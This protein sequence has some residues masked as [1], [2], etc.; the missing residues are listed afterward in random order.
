MVQGFFGSLFAFA[1]VGG[2]LIGGVLVDKAS[3][4]WCFY[5]NLPIGAV[6]AVVL[7]L[8]LKLP[9]P[10]NTGVT[11][12]QK[13][14]KLDPPG[15]LCLIPGVVCLLLA[16]QWGGSVYAWNN[17]RIIALLLL[18][19]VLL[20][21]FVCVQ[22]WR[23]ESG[24]VPPRI[25]KQ[26]SIASAMVY[27]FCSGSAMMVIV[28]NMPIW[29][30]AIKGDSAVQSGIDTLPLLL[31][32]VVATISSGG[33]TTKIGYYTPAMIVS[34][35][36]MSI[37]AGLCT[38]F[39]PDTG[40]PVWI[41]YQII[42]GFG[43]GCA[44]QVPNLAAQCVLAKRDVP[45]GVSLMIFMQMMGGAVFVSV[46]ENV[47]TNRLTTNIGEVSG[48]APAIVLDTGAT[49]LRSAI[50]KA[51]LP[52]VLLAYNNA[53]T[54]TFIVGTVIAAVAIIPALTMEWK[55]VKRFK[56]KKPGPKENEP[57]ETLTEKAEPAS[58]ASNDSDDTKS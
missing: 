40:S 15:N 51:L 16:L 54:S 23:Q 50:P 26:R 30:Q 33:L 1:S 27:S 19:A 42:F 22:I 52:A 43:L 44:M 35:I 29:F 34:P 45:T 56:G 48:I 58:A 10:E 12:T 38:T 9:I 8:I 37:G 25:A 20:I 41:G 57:A 53:I 49:E 14:S 6:V 46:A 31:A 47:F 39:K 3:W 36:I 17:G 55:S 5:I 13:I 21:S 7:V 4:R 18:A 2:P 24:T 28:Y 32:L 11:L